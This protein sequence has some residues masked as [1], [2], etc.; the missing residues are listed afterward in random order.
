M[1]VTRR[2]YALFDPRHAAQFA[3]YNQYSPSGRC[4]AIYLTFWDSWMLSVWLHGRLPSEWEWEYAARGP[5]DLSSDE[6]PIWWWGDD[7][8]ELGKHAW[9]YDNSDGHAHEV[10]TRKT[11]PYGLYDMLGNVW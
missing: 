9:H 1:P 8:S 6:Q 3:D 4:P 2:L 11:N 7:W 5:Q 10:G